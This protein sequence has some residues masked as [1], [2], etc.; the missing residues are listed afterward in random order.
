M[1]Y[2]LL[3]NTDLRPSVLCL[4]STLIGSQIDRET[5]FRLLDEF[6]GQ[7]GT[8]LDTASIYAN[9]LPGPRHVSEKT[10]GAWLKR[11][12]KRRAM[13][14][15][16]KGAHPELA[17]MHVGRMSRQAIEED[18]AASLVNLQTDVIDLYW[19]HRD[20][21][22]RPVAEIVETLEAQ[23]DAGKIRY[24]GCSNWRAERIAAAQA[25]AQAHGYTGFVGDQMQWSLAEVAHG[26][27]ADPTGVVMDEPLWRYHAAS[28]LAA[29][30]YSSQANG[31]FHRMAQGAADTM[32]PN[33]RR[34]YLRP[35]NVQR[36]ARVQQLAAESGLSI[37]AIVLGYLRAQPFVTI[38]IIGPRTLEQLR[39]SLAAADVQLTAEQLR[40]L[41]Q[42]P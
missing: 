29:I 16:T 14:V 34:M 32:N 19:L 39:D 42:E 37:T 6:A 36:A 13:V 27:L 35:A 20:D 40:F 21:V 24:Y 7:G 22:A 28:G 9:W 15:A 11:T 10:I 23:V 41:E 31:F 3:P 33:Q 4:G 2:V 8:F 26:D 5:S 12:G 25:Y 38:P 18:L 1:K 30:P 17:T